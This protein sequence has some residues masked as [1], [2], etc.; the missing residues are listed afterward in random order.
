MKALP[1]LLLPALAI[2]LETTPVARG[3]DAPRMTIGRE[4]AGLVIRWQGNGL[5]ER[6]SSVPG[7]WHP[8]P[9]PA[10]SPFRLAPGETAGFFRVR[11]VFPLTVTN[12]GKGTGTVTS[13][14]E[15]IRCG[16]TCTANYPAG[17]VVTLTAAPA[18]GSTFAGW[19]GDATG[20]APYS[21]A[22]DGPKTVTATFD[23]APPPIGLVNGDFELGPEVGWQ[24]APGQ[25][26]Y[27]ATTVGVPAASGEYVAWLGSLDN[28]H[29]A[30]IGQVVTLPE[31]WPLYLHHA[32]WIYSQEPC[33]VG[34]WDSIGLYVNGE[35]VVENDRLC[36]SDNTVGWNRVSLD[37]SRWAGQ[38][39]S[40]VF[41]L[42]SP[43][44]DPLGSQ[45]L[46][47]ALYL[48]NQP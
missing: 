37:L 39:V 33:E 35:P 36:S 14:P 38:T 48:D 13:D 18:A 21:I 16:A 3:A 5:L 1:L 41:E 8:V 47:D 11:N 27:P 28:S 4:G 17:T 6:A 42:S 9:A 45:V 19:G 24:Q 7:V 2:L 30:A 22:L 34:L 10:V 43:S 40:L 32:V 31:L 44:F 29:S 23:L 15:G 26:I 46:L 12:L 25:L 20:T